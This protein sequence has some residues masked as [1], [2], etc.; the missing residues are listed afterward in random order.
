M[1]LLQIL[2]L[3]LV[4]A[5]TEFLPV[6][7][8]GHLVLASL[9]LG[10][11]Y[12]GIAFDLALHAG[13]LLAV[14]LYFRSDVMAIVR[15]TLAWR[16]GVVLSPVQRL[17]FGLALGTIPGGLAGL[18]LGDAGAM[19]LRDP[20]FIAANL[21]VFGVL[22]GLASRWAPAPT[23]LNS[24][25][26]ADQVFATMSFR[27]A[28]LI[29]CAQ[30]LALMPGVS[31]SGITMTAALLL[32]WNRVAAARY[33]FLLSIPIMVLAAGYEGVQLV[34]SGEAVA[35]GDFALG[36]AVSALAGL[37]VIHVFLGVLRRIGVGPFVVYR[38]LLGVG[39]AAWWLA[40]AH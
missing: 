39:V 11:D 18:A 13:T 17:A 28:F 2:L 40:A 5:L 10:W 8:S 4:Q 21:V 37:G 29:G 34:R 9:L 30:A 1:D 32:G 7:S 25:G 3:A 35:W 24:G 12:Q 38:L 23:E 6:S 15:A 31:R 14:V 22:L 19:W 26:D 16:P 27:H 20:L 36:T 33:A